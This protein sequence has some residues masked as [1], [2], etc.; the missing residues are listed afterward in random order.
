MVFCW[1]IDNSSFSRKQFACLEGFLFRSGFFSDEGP[2]PLYRVTC[3]LERLQSPGKISLLFSGA[4][5]VFLR[6]LE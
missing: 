3:L 5:G 6:K 1:V 2:G 4:T